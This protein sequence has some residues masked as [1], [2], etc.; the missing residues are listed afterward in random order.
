[1]E[2]LEED[3][4]VTAG[5]FADDVDRGFETEKLT[6]KALEARGVVIKLEGFKSLSGAEFNGF[7]GDIQA[8]IGRR[9]RRSD[10]MERR[11]GKRCRDLRNGR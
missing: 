2:R 5:G 10:R 11:R 1:V 7:F 8:Y 4:F 3:E 6:N 9:R